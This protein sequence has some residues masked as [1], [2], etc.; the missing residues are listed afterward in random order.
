MFLYDPPQ[1]LHKSHTVTIPLLLNINNITTYNISE[2]S[3]VIPDDNITFIGHVV[4]EFIR[5][6]HVLLTGFIS[7]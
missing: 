6:I 7:G 1:Q 3:M 2:R 4:N 5:L